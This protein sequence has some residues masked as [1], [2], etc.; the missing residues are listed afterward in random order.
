M[1]RTSND[2]SS[3]KT[4]TT[5][6]AKIA[7]P[8]AKITKIRVGAGLTLPTDY[9]YH[10]LRPYVELEVETEIPLGSREVELEIQ[11]IQ[12]QLNPKIQRLLILQLPYLVGMSKAYG[13]GGMLGMVSEVERVI[14]AD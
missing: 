5:S 3:S 9:D 12:D 8:E 4:T 11:K 2:K 6:K 1:K 10:S 7:T 14:V 13:K